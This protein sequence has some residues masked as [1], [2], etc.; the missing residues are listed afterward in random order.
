M[1]TTQGFP[2]WVQTCLSEDTR[3]PIRFSHSPL[4]NQ[5]F[6]VLLSSSSFWY[7]AMSSFCSCIGAGA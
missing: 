2:G 7:L 1:V 3:N 6:F 5:A 4:M